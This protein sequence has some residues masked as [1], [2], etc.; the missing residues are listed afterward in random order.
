LVLQSLA[1]A[2]HAQNAAQILAKVTKAYAGCRS[3][4]DE[5]SGE[6]ISANRKRHSMFRT[7]FVR[8]A[9]FRY[10]L[11]LPP[12]ESGPWSPWVV[13]KSGD[14]LKVQGLASA[15]RTQNVGFDGAL[16]RMSVYSSGSS[17]AVPP[18]LLPGQFRSSDLVSLMVNPVLAGEETI[19]GRKT[20]RIE[21]T[22]Q[23]FPVKLWI[24]EKQS[25]ILRSYRKVFTGEQSEELTVQY[26]PQID[27]AISPE[28]L[29]FVPSGDGSKDA[30]I[31]R[32]APATK[33]P[34]PAPRLRNFG[35]SLGTYQNQS[36]AL[37]PASQ[38]D[39]VVRVE[40]NLVVSPVLVLDDH[41]RNVKGLTAEDFVVKED[42]KLQKIDTFSLGDN[43]D[44]PRSIVLIVDY[45]NSQFPYLRTSIESAKT[46]VDKL[47]RK[48]RMA[49][50]TDD[51]KLL[52]DFTSDKQLLKTRLEELKTRA[53]SGIVGLSEQYDA[54]LAVL[55]ELF[56]REEDER[57]I[58]IFQTDGDELENL[59][60]NPFQDPY[61]LPRKYDLE[62]IL[63]A[64]T[65]TRSTIYSV[66]SG[67]RF[68]N[69][70]PDDLLKRARRDWENRQRAGVEM[71]RALNYGKSSLPA[72]TSAQPT[73]QALLKQ[74][75]IWLRR[76]T[77]LVNL[78]TATG[79][80]PEFLEEPEQANEIYTRILTD[81]NQ[82]YVI[83]YYPTNRA[84]DGKRRKVS[85]EVRGH[86][87]YKVW[88]QK[89][90]FAREEK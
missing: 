61:V 88:G 12:G 36:A 1:G 59:K 89:S 62:E 15:A 37:T 8:D 48:D 58:V 53:A 67:V 4:A 7:S 72:W 32:E 56:D 82:R 52:V 83:G 30:P 23:G 13:W 69:S 84:R 57:P 39:D 79:A 86:P 75:E 5:G 28:D 24:D 68:V 87:E 51:V 65:R 29:A 22:L 60:G 21:G 43:E 42:D 40:T 41:G 63:T 38:D 9:G 16:S 35:S 10:Q 26:K 17:V 50:V 18:L 81:I 25:L 20:F 44:V 2:A 14:L 64:A 33:N 76:Q 49:I 71:L 70:G 73:E 11:W 27:V 55:N 85:I 47:N 80:A 66:I 31:S 19:E 6:M 34:L 45:S 74:A 3:Y 90:Y 78:S 54:L 46:L 77:A